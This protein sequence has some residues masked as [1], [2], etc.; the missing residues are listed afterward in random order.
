MLKPAMAL[1]PLLFLST[2]HAET[3]L[4][5]YASGKNEPALMK[6]V[7]DGDKLTMNDRYDYRVLANSDAGIVAATGFALT[8]PQTK[9]PVVF[10][11]IFMFE[12]QSGEFKQIAAANYQDVEG[13][14]G[15]CI[16]N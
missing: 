10:G 9:R 5:T 14:H 3:W 16:K 4:C 6:I 15:H 7:I 12:K 8:D 2:A 11:T 1:A 13:T